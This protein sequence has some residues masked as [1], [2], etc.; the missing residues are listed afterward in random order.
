[1]E[2]LIENKCVP[3]SEGEERIQDS[4]LSEYCLQIPEWKI[5]E[6]DGIK[7]LKRNFKFKN[8]I[9]AL[10]FTN[11]VGNAAEEMHHHPVILTQWGKVEVTW[12]THKIK[13]LH[14]N[15]FTMAN[16]TDMLINSFFQ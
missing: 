12:W 5:I 14:K 9:E 10:R 7:K 11:L 15:D 2:N 13:G 6:E 3:C 16:K 4:E 8:F 1:M